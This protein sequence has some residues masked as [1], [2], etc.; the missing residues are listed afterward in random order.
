MAFPALL[1]EAHPAIETVRSF[2]VAENHELHPQQTLG[3]RPANQALNQPGANPRSPVIFQDTHPKLARMPELRVVVNLG[4]ETSDDSAL[5]FRNKHNA[6]AA[7]KL[8]NERFLVL[9][10]G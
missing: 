4:R 7:I 9:N 5:G 6:R 3:A 8:P 2:I 10:A 1:V